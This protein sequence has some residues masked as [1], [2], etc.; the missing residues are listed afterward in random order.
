MDI[1][2]AAQRIL[3]ERYYLPG[4][5]KPEQMFRRIAV[6]VASVEEER[7]SWTETFYEMMTNK[8]FIPNSPTIMNAG[9]EM[10]NLSACFVLPIADDL[11]LIYETLKQAALIFKSGGGCGF[12]FSKLRPRGDLVKKSGGKSSGPVSFMT[13]FDRMAETVEQGGRR[14]GAMLGSLSVHHPDIMKFISAKRDEGILSN[15]NISVEITDEF[16]EAVK[17]RK[18]YELRNPR[19]GHPNDP[20][21]KMVVRRINATAVFNEICKGIWLNGEPGIL[22]VDKIN[23][24]NDYDKTGDENYISTTNPCGEQPL[25]DYGS[26]NLG[27]IN[28]SRF[29]Q[30]GEVDWEGIKE[31]VRKGVRFLDD[32]ISVGKFPLPAIEERAKRER[33]IGLGVMGWHEALLKLGLRYGGIESIQLAGK[34]AKF[35][36]AEAELASNGRNK[37]LLTVA[38][39]GT[40]AMILG[41][42]YGIE[43]IHQISER[44]EVLGGEIL[45]NPNPAVQEI[46]TA[47]DTSAILVTG[48]EISPKRHIDMQAAWQEY[49][50]ASISKTINLPRDFSEE[51]IGEEILYG[52]E[53]GL[54]GMTMYRAGS[55]VGE[56]IKTENTKKLP[57]R[58]RKLVGNTYREPLSCGRTLYPTITKDETGRVQ[59]IFIAGLG[60]VGDCITAWAE[61]FSRAASLYLRI[62]GDPKT[63]IGTLKGIGCPE[64]RNSCPNMIA[65]ILEEETKRKDEEK[66]RG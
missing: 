58:P 8:E 49:V 47:G 63:L 59:E 15:F 48:P 20:E 32:V 25:P 28:L 19:G 44:K 38:P 29:V 6:E 40:T 17:E 57:K 14:R 46:L 23:K 55:R 30:D 18:D 51:R 56:P 3:E 39:T 53:K 61:S 54:K 11:A 22:F 31:I 13:D 66:K 34:M 1:T 27:H 26:C 60:K 16:L 45:A 64:G 33:R 41:T 42:T 43:P 10:N 2:P 4:E 62:G 24:D 7:D 35:I 5:S 52:W 9:T 12:S 36:R 65:K 50:D 21:N 37:R